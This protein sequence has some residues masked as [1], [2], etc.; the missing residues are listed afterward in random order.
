MGQ[1]GRHHGDCRSAE[2]LE[3]QRRVRDGETFEAAAA[4]VGCSSKSVQRLLARTGGVKPCTR[5]T[6]AAAVDAGRA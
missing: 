6:V 3:L 1:G 5:A 4:A 2:R